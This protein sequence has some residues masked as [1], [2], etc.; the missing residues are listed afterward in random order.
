MGGRVMLIT[1]RDCEHKH[2]RHEHGTR[3]AY[4]LDKCRCAECAAANT[5]YMQNLRRRKAIARWNTGNADILADAT[6]TRRRLQ[7]L[8]AM[9]W[10]RGALGA[11]LGTAPGNVARWL[12]GRQATVQPSTDRK[13]RALYERLWATRGPSTQTAKEAR[14]RGWAPPAAWDDDTIDDPAADPVGLLDGDA[15]RSRR[16]LQNVIEEFEHTRPAH[17]GMITVAA[18]K[19]DMTPQALQMVLYRARRRGAVVEFRDDTKRLRATR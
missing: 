14:R 2:A 5:R 19:L 4:N 12:G 11:E 8:V 3:A 13:I 17:G 1:V 7:A 15:P 18:A 6:G 10:T 9:G 16:R